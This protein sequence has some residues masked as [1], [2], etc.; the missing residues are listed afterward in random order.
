M[1]QAVKNFQ[2][3]TPDRAA[4]AIAAITNQQGGIDAEQFAEVV[5]EGGQE[6]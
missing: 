6:A 1:A 5:Q 4:E 2:G 3:T